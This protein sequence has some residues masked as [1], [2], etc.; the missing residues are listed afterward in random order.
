MNSV[1]NLKGKNHRERIHYRFKDYN[2][3]I[4]VICDYQSHGFQINNREPLESWVIICES[5]NPLLDEGEV[6][7]PPWAVFVGADILDPCNYMI[8][9]L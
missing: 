2:E 4:R 9:T 7:I 8:C 5:T 1:K 3:F 6:F